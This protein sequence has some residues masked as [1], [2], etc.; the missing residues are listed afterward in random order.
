MKVR[1]G[2]EKSDIYHFGLITFFSQLDHFWS[3]F[4][5]KCIYKNIEIKI[6]KNI[7]IYIYRNHSTGRISPPRPA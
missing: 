6:E 7:Y 2:L 3:T 5:K 4:G 1:E